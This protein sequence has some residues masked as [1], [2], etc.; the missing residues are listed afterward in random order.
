[1]TTSP[2][3]LVID[4]GTTSTRSLVFD[5]SFSIVASAQEEFQQHFPSSGWVEHLPADLWE[6]TVSTT[7]SA[8]EQIDEKA[9]DIVGIGITNQRETVVIWDQE[10]GKPIHNA[11]VWQDRRTADYCET[12]RKDG[13]EDLVTSKTGLLLDPYFSATKVKW[14]LD[15]VEGAKQKAE[16]GQL[17]FGTVDSWLIWNMT[18]GTH[19]VTDVT[20]ASRTMLYNI[21]EGRWDQELLDLFG[22]PLAMLPE[23]KDCATR[24]GE[25][26]KNLFG[27]ISLPISGVAG[28]QQAATLGQA[29]FQPGMFKSTYGTGCFALLNTGNSPVKSS[30][31]LLT[32]IA[33]QLNGTPTYALEGS[34]FVA[35]AAVQWLR[36]GLG[37]ITDAAST[38]SLAKDAD[39]EQDVYLVP[40][41]TGMGAPWW[42][43]NARGAIFGLTRGTGPKELALATLES[44]CYQTLDLL[45]AMHSDWKPPQETILR[46]D[47]GM[48]ANNWV[49]QR[50]A[51][52]LNAPVDRPIIL[53]TTALGAAW[54]AGHQ[55]EVW[56]DIDGFAKSWRLDQKFSP[57]MPTEIREKKI[58]GWQQAVQRTLT[59]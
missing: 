55:H 39:S 34:I 31:R 7:R 17:A 11:I 58:T 20:N 2:L 33:Y 50:L 5:N 25:T 15:N 38:E 1:M 9:S 18:E 14:I 27:D 23:V 6:T 12:L 32:T 3:I 21:H 59:Q 57:R 24:F 56:P 29:C 53:E 16:N 46:V 42:D 49:M 48:V 43:A 47:G 44:V 28:D 22:I 26:G 35:G 10:T 13:L 8:I 41:F 52:I 37:I 19:H 36:D 30:N 40:A 51:D 54:L 4:Q 45:N